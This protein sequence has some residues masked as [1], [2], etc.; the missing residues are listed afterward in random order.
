[1]A[2]LPTKT[3]AGPEFGPAMT[4][5]IP[6]YRAFVLAYCTSAGAVGTEAARQAGYGHQ[7]VEALR[8]TA[9]RIL[10]KPAVLAAIREVVLQNITADVPVY[11]GALAQVAKNAQHKDQV[12]AIGMLLNRGGLPDVT[13][14]N[15]NV[16]VTM[17]NQ[18]KIAEITQF[19]EEMGLD[20]KTLLGNVTDAD[21]EEIPEGMEGVW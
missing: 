18:Q 17:S 2:S 12:K 21:F 11:V 16:N 6:K 3:D 15:I 13:E 14:K 7:G 20:P 4:V 8:V 10:N 19:A 1:M 5:L 9:S